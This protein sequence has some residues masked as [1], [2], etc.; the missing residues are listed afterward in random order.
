[1]MLR[2]LLKSTSLRP[3]RWNG[4]PSMRSDYFC[5]LRIC[6]T[7]YVYTYI[8]TLARIRIILHHQ[9]EIENQTAGT[10]VTALIPHHIPLATY[11]LLMVTEDA[12][13]RRPT[14]TDAHRTPNEL[15]NDSHFGSNC[16][17]DNLKFVS[18]NLENVFIVVDFLFSPCH[19]CSE[20]KC[21]RR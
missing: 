2:L 4:S 1:M 17:A 18:L 3:K 9:I 12:K 8:Y 5:R 14:H 15:Q 10:A 20:N 13:F 19:R 6:V 7:I 21:E 11:W 16:R